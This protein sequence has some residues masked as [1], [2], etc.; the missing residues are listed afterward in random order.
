MWRHLMVHVWWQL[1]V[2]LVAANGRIWWQLTVAF[3][4]TNGR[5]WRHAKRGAHGGT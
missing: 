1:T 2:H 5:I 4:G 3:G